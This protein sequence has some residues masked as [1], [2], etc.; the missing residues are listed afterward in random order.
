MDRVPYRRITPP[1]H[2]RTNPSTRGEHIN[3]KDSMERDT[4]ISHGETLIMQCIL[5]GVIMVFVLVASM[6]NIAPALA[7][8]GGIRQVLSGAETLDELVTDVRRFGAEWFGWDAPPVTAPGYELYEEGLP[9]YFDNNDYTTSPAQ[10]FYDYN[11]TGA[12]KHDLHYYDDTQLAD[13][14]SNPTVPEPTVT[15]GLWD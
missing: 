14:P 1:R 15:P 6:T 4:A 7:L 2:E 5:S 12:L 3:P 8:R 13:D 10:E 11:D 9:Q